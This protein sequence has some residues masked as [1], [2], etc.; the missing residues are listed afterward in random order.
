RL[1]GNVTK[2]L[3]VGVMNM[4]TK[5]SNEFA[6]QNYTSVALHQQVLERSVV[7]AYFH[8]RDAMEGDEFTTNDYNRTAG[9]EFN[10]FSQDAK[11]QGFGG[12]GLSQSDGLKGD[13]YFYNIGGGY[14]GRNISVYTNVSGIGDNYYADMGWIPFADQY[15][16]VRDTTIH[17]GFHHLF[18]RFSYTFYPANQAKVVSHQLR[19]SHVMDVNNDFDLLQNRIRAGYT[20]SFANTST[21]GLEYGHEDQQLLFPFDFTDAEPLP[22]GRYHFDYLNARYRTD[23][24]KLFSL[25]AGVQYGSFY[26][27]IRFETMLN[28]RYRI[29]PWGNFGI[30]FVYN[31][32]DFPDPYGSE[33]LLLI[34]PRTEINFS[35]NLF[36][37]TFLQFN[38]QKDNFNINSR[39]QW[40]FQPLS[41]L[42]IVYT[43]N[44]F[45]EAWGKK[46]RALVLKLNYWLNI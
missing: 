26:N 46:N 2:D 8:N 37:T 6:G 31:K 5:E 1:S 39:L 13:N 29:Q 14:D 3:R 41:D 23:V 21:I 44:Y 36:W 34:G 33:N 16:A 42:F 38:T 7:K 19:G 45:I 25:Q 10:Y 9:L 32:L 22:P 27:G 24:R 11:W 15:D 12:Y 28:L 40:R 30:N 4:R 17:I 18:T 43:D 20:V 35:R